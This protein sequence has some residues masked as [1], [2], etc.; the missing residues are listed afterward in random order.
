VKQ[1]DSARARL[2]LALVSDDFGSELSSRWASRA[3]GD[4]FVDEMGES[5]GEGE[6][7]E[8]VEGVGVKAMRAISSG[9]VHRAVQVDEELEGSLV[10]A[11][12]L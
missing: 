12:E 11:R 5:T 9:R 2:M 3:L 4:D 6:E 1:T 8:E 10:L 7:E